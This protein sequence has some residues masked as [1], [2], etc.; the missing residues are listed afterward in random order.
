LKP[1]D[2]DLVVMQH[3][4]EYKIEGAMK[5]LSSTLVVKGIN[6]SETAMA[7]TVGLPLG[8]VA[9]EFLKGRI[10]KRGVCLPLDEEIYTP[11]LNGLG[12]AGISFTETV[13]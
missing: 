1:G 13:S 3:E 5:K 4:F 6:T 10:S 7:R 11:V 9:L 2:L 8:I 12:Q